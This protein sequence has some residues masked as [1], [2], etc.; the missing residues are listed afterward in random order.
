M[1]FDRRA[2]LT[3]AAGSALPLAAQAAPRFNHLG[4]PP[5][6]PQVSEALDGVLKQTG[7]PALGYA[8]VG[9]NGLIGIDVAGR[10]RQNVEDYVTQNDSWHI[11]S[12]TKAMTA[13]LYARLAEQGKTKWGATLGELFPS[14]TADPAWK[15]VKIE[16]LFAHRSGI[17]D[18][19]LI[20]QGWLIKAHTDTRPV[21]EQRAEFAARLLGHAPTGKFGE[22]EY[23]NANY[24][25]AGAAMERLLKVDW[26]TLMA[27]EL[28]GPLQ[29]GSAGFGAPTGGAPWGHDPGPNGALEPVDPLHDVADNPPVFGPAGRVHLNLADYAKFAQVFLTG[30]GGWINRVSLA[31]LARP[32]DGKEGYALGW[33]YYENRGWANGPVLAHEGSNTLWRTMALIAPARPIAYLLVT[34][35]GGE[36][37]QRAVQLMA[38]RLIAQQVDPSE[39]GGAAPPQG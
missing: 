24:I 34:N 22:F 23:S 30:G 4:A 29:M 20:D 25:L 8:A 26:E 37:G 18:N 27:T 15:T 28:F 14:V 38:A 13:A 12:N 9:A 11:G 39:T 1:Q 17:S 36:A 33:Q 5:A 19:G 21:A 3:L 31:R 2:F 7:V 16:D 10:R 35:C 6:L 32:W